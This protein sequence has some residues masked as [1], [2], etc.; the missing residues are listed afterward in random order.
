VRRK[1]EEGGYAYGS[2]PYGYR[3]HAGVLVPDE[4]EQAALTRMKDLRAGGA[5]FRAIAATL[6]V[7]AHAPK[8][9]QRW[10]P[11]TIRQILAR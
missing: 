5:S 8:R 6:E 1:A 9:G 2:P 3:V 10:Y 11:M 4:L 7:E